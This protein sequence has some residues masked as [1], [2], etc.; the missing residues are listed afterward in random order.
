MAI[1][2]YK[3]FSSRK[4][5]VQSDSESLR[6]FRRLYVFGGLST[7]VID[8]VGDCLRMFMDIFILPPLIVAFEKNAGMVCCFSTLCSLVAFWILVD[9]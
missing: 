6:S 9:E 7:L 2:Q 4:I 8:S 3:L 5:I 1:K